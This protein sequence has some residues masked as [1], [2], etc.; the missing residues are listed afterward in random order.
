VRL[1]A[2]SVGRVFLA[3]LARSTPGL[4]AAGWGVED[5]ACTCA[6]AVEPQQVVLG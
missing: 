2:A 5:E 3:A 1:G 4:C 6:L